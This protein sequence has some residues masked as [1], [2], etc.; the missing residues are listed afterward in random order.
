MGSTPATPFLAN[1]HSSFSVG[2]KEPPSSEAELAELAL[3]AKERGLV[4]PDEYLELVR[5]ASEIELL[6]GANGCIRFWSAAGTVEMNQA[7]EVQRYLPDALAIGDDE[8][9]KALAM[10]EGEQGPGLYRF[11]F[12]DPDR[13]EAVFI[14]SSV[15]ALLSQGVGVARLFD[16]DDGGS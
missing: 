14:A 6:V 12:S 8:G 4:V 9:G 11:P 2:A 15:R 16:W 13:A 1:L 5:E 7:Y 3:F 10:M